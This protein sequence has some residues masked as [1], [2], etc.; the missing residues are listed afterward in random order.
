MMATKDSECPM[1]YVRTKSD[2]KQEET[3]FVYEHEDVS[4]K[5]VT[6]TVEG[7]VTTVTETTKGMRTRKVT[8]KTYS[9]S[10]E[11][12]CEHFFEALERLQKE[13][14]DEWTEAKKNKTNDATHLF[15][16]FEHMLTGT[17]NSEWHDVLGSETSRT[18]ETFKAK[19]AEFICTRVL[20][21]DAYNRQ[22]TYMQERVKPM[23]LT[24]KQWWL[25]MQTMNRYLPY[26]IINMEALKRENPTADFKSWWTS[27]GL[28]EAELK[29]T[30]IIKVP[31]DWQDKLRIND[32]GH[33]YR[34]KKSIND[35]IDYYTTLESLERGKRER[36]RRTP[37]GRSAPTRSGRFN[38]RRQPYYGRNPNQS[39]YPVRYNNYGS[40]DP[41][42]G[43]ETSCPLCP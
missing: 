9:H 28:S 23:A 14:E 25:R 20:P 37:R 8:L 15:A 26:F 40:A 18:W 5:I 21:E 3:K 41:L 35:L 30:I 33:D 11:E 4:E 27:G 10:S 17:A 24:A 43:G 12:D 38:T 16:A 1:P 34:D 32:V 6:S 2:Y 39:G 31:G 7:K 19:V 13:L 36:A 29:R 22:V 42:S